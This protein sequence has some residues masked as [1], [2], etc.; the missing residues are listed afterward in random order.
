MQVAE[1]KRFIFEN[2][3]QKMILGLQIVTYIRIFFWSLS[4]DISI[5][6]ILSFFGHCH[7]TFPNM[8]P[9]SVGLYKK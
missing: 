5:R 9:P 7:V 4:R 6:E 2:E 1:K 8:E 3:S